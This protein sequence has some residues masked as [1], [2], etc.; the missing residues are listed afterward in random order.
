[1]N[2]NSLNRINHLTTDS[3]SQ[4][5]QRSHR[6][7][8][9]RS[10]LRMAECPS[11]TE[12]TASNRTESTMQNQQDSSPPSGKSLQQRAIDPIITTALNGIS[13]P[14]ER[15]SVSHK[16]EQILQNP[17]RYIGCNVPNQNISDEGAA[18]LVSILG[19]KSSLK[20]WDFSNNYIDDT[21]VKTLEKLFSNTKNL[22]KL[23]LNGNPIHDDG[24]TTLAVELSKNI[25][26]QELYLEK[27]QIG[28]KGLADFLKALQNNRTL[29]L[30]LVSNDT[31]KADEG[32]FSTN[33]DKINQLLDR[34]RNIH[35]LF[36]QLKTYLMNSSETDYLAKIEKL[37]S[38]PN[39]HEVI[40]FLRGSLIKLTDDI[41]G[42]RKNDSVPK[43]TQTRRLKTLFKKRK[44][45]VDYSKE[46]IQA[47]D[48]L[49][50]TPSEKASPMNKYR[51]ESWEE[52]KNSNNELK[53]ELVTAFEGNL[54]FVV[55]QY[56][57]GHFNTP[58]P[59]TGKLQ[60][61]H[62]IRK[63]WEEVFGSECPAWLVTSEALTTLND[64]LSVLKGE[65]V[66][67]PCSMPNAQELLTSLSNLIEQLT[68]EQST[69]Q[70]TLKL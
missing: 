27:T 29:R 20:H 33:M 8:R 64:F 45:I 61:A 43:Q 38:S 14:E 50:T 18:A 65:T 41:D 44:N 57:D 40:K 68:T 12:T 11:G 28:D 21:G 9:G 67:V 34:N 2:T 19:K 47:L 10:P 51:E 23:N 30:L 54:G 56:Q 4:N 48:T 42:L 22:T 32:S 55:T 66:D 3:S 7:P 58:L 53:N 1:M 52:I 36:N 37:F 24:A 62:E 39:S 31:I 35:K 60:C 13:N 25:T 49:F 6:S 5:V 17:L 70:T 63:G 16:I 46:M 69:V 59:S 26:L 15:R